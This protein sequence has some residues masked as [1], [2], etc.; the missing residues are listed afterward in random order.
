MHTTGDAN[1][2]A[3]IRAPQYGT[4]APPPWRVR[5]Y[6]PT[7]VNHTG[8]IIICTN[9]IAISPAVRFVPICQSFRF[10]CQSCRAGVSGENDTT[11]P[12]RPATAWRG[13]RIA[14]I[15][16]FALL[17]PGFRASAAS[18]AAMGNGSPS[19]RTLEAVCT[20][21]PPFQSDYFAGT[22]MAGRKNF[23]PPLRGYENKA[24]S[25]SPK[26]ASVT[27]VALMRFLSNGEFPP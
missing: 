18:Q 9:I 7:V 6:G 13:T 4:H 27:L 24:V 25:P 2:P 23:T 8:N 16:P 12:V 11:S 10:F 17:P 26:S 22:S 5:T 3:P 15:I 1:I 19:Y 20:S 14:P 21:R